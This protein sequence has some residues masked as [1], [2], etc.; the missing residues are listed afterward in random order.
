[1]RQLF[2]KRMTPARILFALVIGGL[3]CVSE[4]KVI[5]VGPQSLYHTIEEAISG[6]LKNASLTEDVEIVVDVPD[7]GYTHPEDVNST[8]IGAWNGFTLE[9]IGVSPFGNGG[10]VVEATAYVDGGAVYRDDGTGM[11]ADHQD[12]SSGYGLEG[13]V[14]NGGALSYYGFDHLGSTRVVF[15]SSTQLTEAIMYDLYGAMQK[16][17]ASQSR[18]VVQKFTGQE[19]DEDGVNR[20]Q[21][22]ERVYDPEVGVWGSPDPLATTLNSYGYVSA[23]PVNRIDLLG[24]RDIILG[25]IDIKG[26][27]PLGV[28]ALKQSTQ[29]GYAN[30][31][32]LLNQYRE[33]INFQK[34]LAGAQERTRVSKYKGP[35]KD[36]FEGLSGEVFDA[37]LA[38]MDEGGNRTLGKV[39][40]I[41]Y[42]FMPKSNTQAA[43]AAVGL[44]LSVITAGGS[45]ELMEGGAGAADLSA[46][47][48]MVGAKAFHFTTE[49][50]A[51]SI[52]ENGLRP[53]SYLTPT[54]GLSPIQASI[55]LALNPAG[56]A[57]NVMLEID[58]QGLRAAG[59][60]I[61]QAT[62]VSGQFGM[63]GGGYEMQFPYS[64]PKE[65][66]KSAY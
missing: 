27:S 24:L 8:D 43:V 37:V 28:D 40:L 59:Y 31:K 56:G 14:E 35:S 22:K 34:E 65:F 23:D 41:V 19:Y 51:A 25:N 30:P 9:V 7:E 61:P 49:E 16:L 26:Q 42:A 46:A 36:A 62:R 50:F 32:E 55:E 39:Y 57:R 44:G 18:S 63:A 11:V 21:F 1:M 38:N 60:E 58:L 12:I 15:S 20:I 54:S 5:R 64:I 2:S 4:G 6:E 48:G 66:I 52:L 13:R 3:P 29:F 17:Q 45:L 10:T 33:L 53:G 47:E